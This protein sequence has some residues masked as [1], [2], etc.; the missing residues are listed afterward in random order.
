MYTSSPEP[1][2]LSYPSIREIR[3]DLYSILQTA[4]FM[5]K[6]YEHGMVEQEVFFKQMGRF[7]EELRQMEFSLASSKKSLLDIIEQ[8]N[9][10]QHLKEIFKVIG[11]SA[12]FTFDQEHSQWDFNPVNLA[13]SSAQV[14]SSF[15][16]VIDYLHL[17]EQVELPFLLELTD[18]LLRD[19]Q[20]YEIFYP[21]FMQVLTL[22]N[23]ILEII[24]P[25]EG[26]TEI[27]ENIIVFIT[28]HSDGHFFRIHQNFQNFLKNQ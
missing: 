8:L 17:V 18:N 1:Q 21:F 10:S 24:S 12:D 2:D 19:L 25:Y 6:R 11:T 7:Q 22:K 23:E 5:I 14:T 15:I 16:T 26:A 20:T 27:P 13:A 3:A 9:N 4:E 28:R